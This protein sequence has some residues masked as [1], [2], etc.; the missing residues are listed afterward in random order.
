MIMFC[1]AQ[2]ALHSQL[3]ASAIAKPQSAVADDVLI[4]M[5]PG[6]YMPV[7]LMLHPS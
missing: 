2:L 6:L 7:F 3:A 5:C 1:G 4:G